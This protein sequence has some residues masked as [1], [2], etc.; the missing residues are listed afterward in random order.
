MLTSKATGAAS[1]ADSDSDGQGA[2]SEDEFDEDDGDGDD[3]PDFGDSAPKI[4]IVRSGPP[5]H[6]KKSKSSR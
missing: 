5:K 4:K 1:N 2:E 6:I 3:D